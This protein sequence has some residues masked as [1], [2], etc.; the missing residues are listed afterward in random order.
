MSKIKQTKA[1]SFADIAVIDRRNKM[2]NPFLSQINQLVDWHPI[3]NLLN[4]QCL[5][6]A[7]TPGSRGGCFSTLRVALTTGNCAFQ[8]STPREHGM[9]FPTERSKSASIPETMV[10]F[11]AS[12]WSFTSVRSSKTST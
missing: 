9:G 10:S 4:K 11:P 8:N 6:Q 2:R 7:P 1:P 12:C 5:K 3:S